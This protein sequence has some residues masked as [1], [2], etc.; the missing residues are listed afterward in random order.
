MKLAFILVLMLSIAGSALAQ[1]ID[2]DEVSNPG[3]ASQ[4]TSREVIA[5][6]IDEDDEEATGYLGGYLG[7]ME[8]IL[9]MLGKPNRTCNKFGC[10]S[11]TRRNKKGK[12]GKGINGKCKVKGQDAE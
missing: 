11:C 12:S 8:D 7:A 3:L 10:C 9:A 1:P 4:E 5:S 6:D 2:G